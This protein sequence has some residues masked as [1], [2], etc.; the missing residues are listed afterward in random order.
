M[1]K[2][3]CIHRCNA[4]FY[5]TSGNLSASHL[6]FFQIFT[7]TVATST[8][9]KWHCAT[10]VMHYVDINGYASKSKHNRRMQKKREKPT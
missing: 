1:S 4:R 8:G 5:V 10:C 3:I 2:H 9:T 7:V 6:K